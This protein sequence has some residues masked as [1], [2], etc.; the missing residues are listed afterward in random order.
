MGKMPS[1]ASTCQEHSSAR[2]R[3]LDQKVIL[4]VPM[5]VVHGCRLRINL[6]S[7][8]FALSLSWGLGVTSER[9]QLALV[10]MISYGMLFTLRCS[11]LILSLQFWYSEHRKI[12][13]CQRSVSRSVNRK[14]EKY[15]DIMQ[16]MWQAIDHNILPLHNRLS[17]SQ[18]EIDARNYGLCPLMI[19]KVYWFIY[20][21]IY[22]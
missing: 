18:Q 19:L 21:N 20:V 8:V 10:R 1:S 6:I 16:E 13:R 7:I 22:V 4:M 5:Q 15:K 2:T 12:S 3:K 9:P 11:L 17:W 14:P